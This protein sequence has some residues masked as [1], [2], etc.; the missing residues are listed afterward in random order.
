MHR[1]V[2]SAVTSRPLDRIYHVPLQCSLARHRKGR[3]H[4]DAP[5]RRSARVDPFRTRVLESVSD[6]VGVAKWLRRQV[7][8]L[9][10]EGSNPF[11][12]PTFPFLTFSKPL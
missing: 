4:R 1:E 8:A 11:T 5:Q 7:V 6:T 12:H 9:E 2:K 3:T 10:I